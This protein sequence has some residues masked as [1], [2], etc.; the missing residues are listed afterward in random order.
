[1]AKRIM[2]IQGDSRV[3]SA[4]KVAIMMKSVGVRTGRK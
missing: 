4:R 2:R 3:K 1:M